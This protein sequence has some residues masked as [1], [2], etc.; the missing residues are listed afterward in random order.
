[1]VPTA[2]VTLRRMKMLV[3]DPEYTGTVNTRDLS[4]SS[5]S[6]VTVSGGVE[7]RSAPVTAS[8]PMEMYAPELPSD[9][10]R[11]LRMYHVS[12][13]TGTSCQTVCFEPRPSMRKDLVPYTYAP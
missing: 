1:M 9:W 3:F 5:N 6:P 13:L 12:T 4:V 10:M 2:P 7:T 11:P 8:D